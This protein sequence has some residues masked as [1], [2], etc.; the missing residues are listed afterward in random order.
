MSNIFISL[1]HDW[2]KTDW[3][4]N[5]GVFLGICLGQFINAAL[6]SPHSQSAY[7][8]Y[9]LWSPSTTTWWSPQSVFRILWNINC[10]W[11]GCKNSWC[12]PN[13]KFLSFEFFVPFYIRWI[14]FLG[15]LLNRLLVSRKF[16]YCFSRYW[17]LPVAYMLST[18]VSFRRSVSGS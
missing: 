14:I 13:P 8:S 3:S 18:I 16:W 12:L 10:L 1:L 6:V 4:P 11:R 2:L 7:S 5:T 17:I 9:K 15:I